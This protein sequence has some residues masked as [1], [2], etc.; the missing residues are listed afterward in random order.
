MV[1]EPHA[2]LIAVYPGTFDPITRGHEDLVKRACALFARVIVCVAAGHHK[3]TLFTLEERLHLARDCVTRVSG[4]AVMPMTGLL[5]DFALAQKA[6]VVIRGLR[7]VSDFDYEFQLA[8]VNRHLMPEV[9]TV[10]LTPGDHYQ[11][12]SASFVREIALLGGD[13][14]AFVSPLVAEQLRAKAAQRNL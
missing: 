14:S 4:A 3:K 10:F 5:S 11:F 6:R 1:T 2:S 8:G 13:V 7:A 9:E 12:I